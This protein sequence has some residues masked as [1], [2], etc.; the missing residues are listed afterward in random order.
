MNLK[1]KISDDIY[2][3]GASDRRIGKFEN[4]IPLVNGVSYNSYLIDDQKTC[5]L[6]TVDHSVKDIFIEKVKNVLNGKKL[7]YLV[8]NHMEGDHTSAIL[9]IV[10]MYPDVILVVNQK[11]VSMLKQF[12]GEFE[13][14]FLVVDEKTVLDL[15]KHKLQF[16]FAPMV[17]WPEVMVCYDQ[18]SKTLFSADAFGTFNALSGHVFSNLYDFEHEFL[19]ESRRYYSNIVGKYGMNVQ[20]LLKKVSALEIKTI[21]SLHGPVYNKDIPL[22]MEKYNK[23]SKYEAESDGFLIIYGSAYGNTEKVANIIADNLSQHSTNEIKII[24]SSM[25]D[26]S[27]L[28]SESF[29]FKNIIVCSPTYN[30]GIYPSIERYI[31]E[32]KNHNLQNRN[33]ALID[34]GSWCPMCNVL[35]S[36]IL[37]TMQNINILNSS[38]SFKSS[39][40]SDDYSKIDKLVDELLNL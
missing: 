13:G 28:I 35:I 8:I 27:Y 34:N 3:V 29:K 9:E 23:W 20:M 17:H 15:G 30:A 40:N 25:I 32:I 19:S 37:Q 36:K 2:Y 38:F 24:D 21:C 16:L 39:L 1:V 10:H 14:N 26:V 22:M 33:F 7:D 31:T 6:D 18:T 12:F 5:L 4:V 11:T